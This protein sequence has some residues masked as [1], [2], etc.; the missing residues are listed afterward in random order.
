MNP[1]TGSVSL[2]KIYLFLQI[3]V[4]GLFDCVYFSL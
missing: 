2:K 4:E 3:S 1:S